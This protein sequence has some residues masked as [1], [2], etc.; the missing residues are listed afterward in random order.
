MGSDDACVDVYSSER[1]ERVGYCRG[2]PS[3]VTHID[4][5]HDS[6]HLQVGP[7]KLCWHDYRLGHYVGIIGFKL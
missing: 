5:S 6:K 3:S 2:I 1:F 4:W 7:G